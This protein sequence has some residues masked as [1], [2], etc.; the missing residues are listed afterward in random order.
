[1]YHR[2]GGFLI[3]IRSHIRDD[4]GEVNCLLRIDPGCLIRDIL[5]ARGAVVRILRLTIVVAIHW[6]VAASISTLWSFG[7]PKTVCMLTSPTA[8]VSTGRVAL[9]G[10][11]AVFPAPL[12]SK[13]IAEYRREHPGVAIDYQGV[14]SG[15]SIKQ[16]MERSIDFGAT[17][18][19]MTDEQLVAAH[20]EVLHV[21]VAVVGVV[22]V[23][24]LPGLDRP[25]RLDGPTIADIFLGTIRRWND[26]RLAELNPDVLLPSLDIVPVF[27]ADGSGTTWLVTEY[28]SKVSS[29]FECEVGSGFAVRWPVGRGSKGSDGSPA[30]V[31]AT[32]GAIGFVELTGARRYA[33]AYAR[34]RN[35]SGE[36]VE[37][38]VDSLRAASENASLP[39]DLRGSI[40]DA[41]GRNTYPI[42]GL[43]YILIPTR[44]PDGAR[45]RALVAFVTWLLRDERIA[46]ELGYAHV[47][48]ALARR[49]ERLLERVDLS[50][51]A[52]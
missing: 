16:I 2:G 20:G 14:G 22:I 5:G 42:A 1:M 12:Y 51:G 35:G 46:R 8:L 40:V 6:L 15:S 11:G 7:G 36:F 45:A 3:A 26:P 48:P 43:T 37:P 44:P 39:D 13:Y 33:L 41:G 50:S 34:I 25:L 4:S 28:L 23:Y 32:T 31:V 47:P 29:R 17:D 52:P 10:A 30:T 21:P 9:Q 18:A 24:N 19:P 49:A 38:T 27:R